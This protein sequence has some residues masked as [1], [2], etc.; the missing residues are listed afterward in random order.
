MARVCTKE[1]SRMQLTTFRRIRKTFQRTVGYKRSRMKIPV[2]LNSGSLPGWVILIRS[3]RTRPEQWKPMEEPTTTPADWTRF[4]VSGKGWSQRRY[5]VWVRIGTRVGIWYGTDTPIC[6]WSYSG[7]ISCML[8]TVAGSEEND[9][10][11]RENVSMAQVCTV[12]HR[13]LKLI[14]ATNLGLENPSCKTGFR[15]HLLPLP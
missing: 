11:T 2:H 7:W 13:R 5:I 12:E 4:S 8:H 15:P 10:F 9:F 14:I 1:Y 3:D 6:L